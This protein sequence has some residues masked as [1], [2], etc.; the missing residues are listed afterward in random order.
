M[1]YL[2]QP[3]EKNG[4]D[5]SDHWKIFQPTQS[6]APQKRIAVGMPTTTSSGDSGLGLPSPSWRPR[7][8]W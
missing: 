4:R 2:P 3:A 8:K 7:K 6:T 5:E 1:G